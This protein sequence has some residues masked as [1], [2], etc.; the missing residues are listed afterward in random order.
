[1]HPVVVRTARVSFSLLVLLSS[2]D[3]YIRDTAY[4]VSPVFAISINLFLSDDT[5]ELAFFFTF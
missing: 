3:L 2:N 5:D 1:M 4:T